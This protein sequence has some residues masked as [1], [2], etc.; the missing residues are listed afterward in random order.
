MTKEPALYQAD[1]VE[2]QGRL[3]LPEGTGRCPGVLDRRSW[4]AMLDLFG[5]VLG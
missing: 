2:M 5:E 3:F 4:Q 1:G